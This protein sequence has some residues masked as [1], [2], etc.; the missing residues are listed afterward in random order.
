MNDPVCAR[1]GKCCLLKIDGKLTKKHCKYL[2]KIGERTL[3]RIYKTRLG[4]QIGHGH[5]CTTRE[6]DKNNYPGCPLNA[7]YPD[8]PI[9]EEGGK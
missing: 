8:K 1:C 9:I 7:L 4:V 5:S 6:K 2:I 3:C